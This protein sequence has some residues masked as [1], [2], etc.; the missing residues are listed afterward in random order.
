MCCKENKVHGQYQYKSNYDCSPLG[1]M[2]HSVVN[3]KDISEEPLAST[4]RVENGGSIYF[5]FPFIQ[6]CIQFTLSLQKYK[7][8]GEVDC[9]W[10]KIGC[11]TYS[12]AKCCPKKTDWPLITL[13]FVEKSAWYLILWQIITSDPEATFQNFLLLKF[14][15]L[16]SVVRVDH[17]ILNNSFLCE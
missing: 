14:H 10:I 3:V 11:A 17:S 4:S 15:N 5:S 6:P 8:R 9:G 13:E 12:L 7:I 1:V 2:A 16:C